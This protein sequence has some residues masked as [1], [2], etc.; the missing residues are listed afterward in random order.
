M[1]LQYYRFIE[2]AIKQCRSSGIDCKVHGLSI[3]G[4]RKADEDDTAAN[5]AFLAS[6]DE[7][8]D[9]SSSLQTC[10][11]KTRSSGYREIQTHVLVWGLNDKDQLGGPKGSKVNFFFFSFFLNLL[12]LI[13]TLAYTCTHKLTLTL[14][15]AQFL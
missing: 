12:P 7:E 5:F 15:P 9:R 14:H 13:S 10:R 4:R 8:E 3:V 2:I 6:D 11:K 1:F